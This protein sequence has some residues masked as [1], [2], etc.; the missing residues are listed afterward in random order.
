[1]IEARIIVIYFLKNFKV[2]NIEGKDPKMTSRF[3]HEPLDDEL[4]Q[5]SPL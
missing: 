2:E 3:L 1:M 5:L 4:V